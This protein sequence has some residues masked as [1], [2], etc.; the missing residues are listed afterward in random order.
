MFCFDPSIERDESIAQE[1][2][3][4]EQEKVGVVTAVER[5]VRSALLVRQRGEES[6]PGRDR[7]RGVRSSRRYSGGGTER[8][9]KLVDGSTGWESG[10]LGGQARRGK[11]RETQIV[12]GWKACGGKQV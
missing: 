5:E 1:T 2:T 3:A 12:G 10:P 11:L 7:F 4:V 8:E 9:L 6:I